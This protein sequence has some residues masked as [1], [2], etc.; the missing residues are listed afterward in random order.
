MSAGRARRL[1]FNEMARSQKAAWARFAE[2]H[3]LSADEWL[4]RSRDLDDPSVLTTACTIL[5]R[6]A[7]L[8]LELTRIKLNQTRASRLDNESGGGLRRQAERDASGSLSRLFDAARALADDTDDV[9]KRDAVARTGTLRTCYQTNPN[10][11]SSERFSTHLPRRRRLERPRPKVLQPSSGPKLR[12][13]TKGRGHLARVRH[14]RRG[15][16]CGTSFNSVRAR[17]GAL[18]FVQ[19]VA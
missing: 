10:R 8:W 18:C 16:R 7:K 12:V 4:A 19:A 9:E 14:A 2:R 15:R 3:S 11:S 13:C 6:E 1:R 17:A 5:P